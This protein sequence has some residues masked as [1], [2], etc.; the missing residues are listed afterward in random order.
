MVLLCRLSNRQLYVF[1]L[2][3]KVYCEKKR[4]GNVGVFKIFF[5]RAN[6]HVAL[7]IGSKISNSEQV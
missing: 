5:E 3:V 2:L 7:N 1:L 4:N 6:F